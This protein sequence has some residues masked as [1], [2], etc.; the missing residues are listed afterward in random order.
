MDFGRSLHFTDVLSL[1]GE[2]R[3]SLT[4]L[5]SEVVPCL[6]QNYVNYMIPCRFRRNFPFVPI[7]SVYVKKITHIFGHV[8][9]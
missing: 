7:D 1:N 5:N 9:R 6:V 3:L 4:V 2:P 8:L